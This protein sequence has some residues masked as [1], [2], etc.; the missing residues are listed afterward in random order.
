MNFELI[1]K[2]FF[3]NVPVAEMV[4]KH[5]IKYTRLCGIVKQ[6]CIQNNIDFND[7][8]QAKLELPIDEIYNDRKKGLSY[9]KIG[10]KYGCADETIKRHL[11][12][13]C[14]KTKIPYQLRL[15]LDLKEILINAEK[16]C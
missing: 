12:Q 10:K 16:K 15:L 8:I 6:Y 3:D 1:I 9:V 14:N 11:I 2:D 7:E 5:N 4:K 13:Y